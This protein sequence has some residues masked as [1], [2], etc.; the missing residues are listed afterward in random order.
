MGCLFYVTSPCPPHVGVF[1]WGTPLS[2]ILTR[3]LTRTA[4]FSVCCTILFYFLFAHT[5]FSFSCSVPFLASF[6]PL[7]PLAQ[8]PFGCGV[9]LLRCIVLC[10]PWFSPPCMPLFCAPVLLACIGAK[11]ATQVILFS[12]DNMYLASKTRYRW[13]WLAR[14][15]ANAPGTEIIRLSFPAV[16]SLF[17]KATG[18]PRCRAHFLCINGNGHF[19]FY[20]GP[21]N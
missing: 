4:G 15:L 11:G 2:L 16:M 21:S 7:A 6:T 10:A 9:A 12:R 18:R 14:P 20:F 17:S 13:S 19:V 5:Y 8:S 3:H 1:E